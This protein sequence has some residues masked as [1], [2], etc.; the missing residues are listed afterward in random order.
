MNEI[1]NRPARGRARALGHLYGHLDGVDLLR[2]MIE[3][4][5]PGRIALVSSFGA[6]AA[7]LLDL[8]AQVDPGMPVIFL[9]T[10]KLFPETLAYRRR[11][12]AH[13]GLT[14]LH[15]VRP[16]VRELQARD[17][18][19]SLWR[20]NPD[21]CC[22]L[23]KVLPLERALTGFEA[24]VNGRKR[25]HGAGRSGIETIEATGGRIKINPLARW[26]RADVEAAFVARDLPPHPLV[27][28]GYAS[29]GCQPCT[30]RVGRNMDLRAGRWP[31]REKTEC[32]IHKAEWTGP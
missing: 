25:F 6:E 20:R 15:T 8:V 5:F 29:I 30:G 28:E 32:G 4:E 1:D 12:T 18:D 10:G 9:D 3:D 19:G 17:P 27:D 2:V 14:N 31:G 7:V 16:D 13:L 22:Y 21:A 26:S 11:L 24:W 23:R